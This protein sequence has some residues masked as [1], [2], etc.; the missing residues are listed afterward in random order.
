MVGSLDRF[1]IF[2]RFCCGAIYAQYLVD[3]RNCNSNFNE[4]GNHR[5][6]YHQSCMRSRN[7]TNEQKKRDLLREIRGPTIFMII[8]FGLSLKN[9]F[10]H[11]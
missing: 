10:D 4:D 11:Y 6:G 7:M 5:R 2:T 8:S 9:T 1:N 3:T